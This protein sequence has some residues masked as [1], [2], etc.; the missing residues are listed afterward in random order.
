M[1]RSVRRLRMTQ[2]HTDGLL[3]GSRPASQALP[4]QARPQGRRSLGTVVSRVG[5]T[6]QLRS[7][8]PDGDDRERR[9]GGEL[10]LRPHGAGRDS[11]AFLWR[12]LDSLYVN[13]GLDVAGPG[14]ATRGRLVCCA[15]G[16]QRDSERSSRLQP[17]SL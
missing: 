8:E 10:W 2:C 9:G 5:S 13:H 1:C 16:L 6:R 12:Y 11:S 17:V 15:S 4:R 7:E 14:A 3:S